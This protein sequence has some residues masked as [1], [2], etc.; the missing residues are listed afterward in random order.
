MRD[1]AGQGARC[2]GLEG[3]AVG[4]RARRAFE[5]RDMRRRRAA[6]KRLKLMGR[7]YCHLELKLF[8]NFWRLI[9][10]Q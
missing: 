2:A 6:K 7:I 8:R 4:R 9:A 10:K 3:R 5:R 1:T